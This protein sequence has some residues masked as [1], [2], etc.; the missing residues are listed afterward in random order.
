MLAW[1]VRANEI[2]LFMPHGVFKGKHENTA[3]IYHPSLVTNLFGVFSTDDH[4][5]RHFEKS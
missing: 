2:D 3:V 1:C 4:E 5:R